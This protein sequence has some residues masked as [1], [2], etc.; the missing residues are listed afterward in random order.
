MTVQI[1]CFLY[2]ARKEIQEIPVNGASN[3]KNWKL[4]AVSGEITECSICLSVADVNGLPLSFTLDTS[5]VHFQHSN[6][7]NFTS[8]VAEQTPH[9]QTEQIER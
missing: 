1:M 6:R 9:S 7:S 8:E 5:H 3:S 4:T 2:S